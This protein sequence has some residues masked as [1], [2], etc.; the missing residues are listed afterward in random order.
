MRIDRITEDAK[1][2]R[3][4]R[5]SIDFFCS[6]KKVLTIIRGETDMQHFSRVITSAF[7]STLI[8]AAAHAADV[9]TGVELNSSYIYHGITYNDGAVIQ[10]WLDVSKNGFGINVWA[11]FDLDDYD[12]YYVKNVFSEVDFSLYYCS[13]VAEFDI[14]ATYAEYL[15]PNIDDGRGGALE[16]DREVLFSF[17]RAL[18]AGLR[19]Q[20]KFHINVD[21]RVEVYGQL[22]LVYDYKITD[23]V[24]AAVSAKGAWVGDD[25]TITGEEGLH[26]YDVSFSMTWALNENMSLG[27][28]VHSIGS[29]DEDVLPDQDV[30]L[31]GGVSLTATL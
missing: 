24:S 15:Y 14:C 12:G 13:S 8:F 30:D 2:V 7:A 3:P 18:F 17:D 10:P 31:Y 11:N 27:A 28:N 25:M 4:R 23:K 19:T 1:A 6:C 9:S 20:A 26:D 22:L 16:G 29:L 21:G 5:A